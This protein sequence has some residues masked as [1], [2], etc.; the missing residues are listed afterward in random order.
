MPRISLRGHNPI[1]W[2]WRSS[3]WLL[4]AF[5]VGRASH[6]LPL[7]PPSVQDPGPPATEHVPP[8]PE[9]ITLDPYSTSAK[10]L[11]LAQSSLDAVLD[12]QS[13]T[14]DEA[15]AR[16]SLKAARPPPPNF[17]RWFVFA[18]ENKCLIDD[19]DQIQRDFEPF[20]QLAIDHPAYFQTMIEKGQAMVCTQFVIVIHLDVVPDFRRNRGIEPKT[21]GG[22]WDDGDPD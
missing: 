17:D 13:T 10:A 1:R 16:Y 11:A 6:F 2:S 18:Q 14:L 8:P 20:Y 9:H 3:I 7:F 5:A 22:S 19:Y 21:A 12:R 15:V 4:A